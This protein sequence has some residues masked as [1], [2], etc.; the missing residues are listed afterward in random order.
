[1]HWLSPK[2]EIYTNSFICESDTELALASTTL[3]TNFLTWNDANQYCKSIGQ[4]LVTI[5]EPA[6]QQL[7][8]EAL[9]DIEDNTSNFEGDIWIGLHVPDLN[10]PTNCV[11]TNDCLSSDS[12]TN[13]S[14]GLNSDNDNLCGYVEVEYDDMHWLLAD[15]GSDTKTFICESDTAI[16]KSGFYYEIEDDTRASIGLTDIET[17]GTEE[18]CIDHCNGIAVCWAF[19]FQS[20]K[21]KCVMYD[22]NEDNISVDSDRYN[23]EDNTANFEGD[24]WI[25]L[26]VPDL[27]QPT[28]CVWTNDCLSS[29]SFS[30]WLPGLNSGNDNLCVYM[31][32]EY[33]DMYWLLADCGSDTNTFICES[34]TAIF[35][36]GFYY[37]IEYDTRA[38]IGLTGIVTHGTEEEC[39]DHCNGIP[40]CWAFSF[41]S[42]TSKCVMYEKIDGPYFTNNDQI[43]APGEHLYM[44]RN[45]ELNEDNTVLS[46]PPYDDCGSVV[47]SDCVVCVT[48]E[49]KT[50]TEYTTTREKV[51]TSSIVSS[52]DKTTEATM[53]QITENHLSSTLELTSSDKTTETTISPTI[54]EVTLSVLTTTIPPTTAN[55]V[56]SSLKVATS[57]FPI[58][59]SQTTHNEQSKG[60][61]PYCVCTC[62]NVTKQISLEESINEIV[63]DIKVDRTKTSSYTRKLTSAWDS[64]KSSATIGFVGITLL[65]SVAFLLLCLDSTSLIYKV[66]ALLRKPDTSLNV[67]NENGR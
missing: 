41:Q 35:K 20:S 58:T 21:S 5:D 44:K 39:I 52:V 14:P 10:Q 65:I 13:W 50:T 66:L 30:N 23:R 26:H 48:T 29:D 56:T 27:N 54:Q 34:D 42:S 3:F 33:D 4:H 17:H 24:I 55:H 11:W 40:F 16:F 62:N 47:V 36:S 51:T 61:T 60:K 8:H 19:S 15:C 18:E 31:K 49:V 22:N 63:N 43:F 28:N 45:F 2:C 59:T 37:E 38:S 12:F 57:D 25:G 46:V 7:L 9:L 53:P 67:H 1:M 64:R 6:K 32:V